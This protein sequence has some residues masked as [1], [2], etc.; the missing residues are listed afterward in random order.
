MAKVIDIVIKVRN[1]A[2]PKLRDVDRSLKRTGMQVK[3]T[4][5]DFTKFNRTLFTTAAFIGTFVKAFQTAVST[6]DA[7]SQLDRVTAQ[8]ERTLGGRGSLIRSIKDMS[9]NSI[10]IIESM[11]AGIALK[12]LGI[13]KSTE[14]LASIVTK[15][16]TA[17]KL[18]GKDSGEGIKSF[19]EFLKTG[20]VENL[21]FL[22][23]I[24]KTNPALKAQLAI[25]RQSGGVMSGVI[26]DAQKLAI[27]Q[28]LL[29]AATKGHLKGERDLRDIL[30]DAGQA[31]K[32]MKAEIGALLGKALGPLIDK[33]TGAVFR[34]VELLEST[35]KTD[36]GI[37]FLVKT[38]AVGTSA[39]LGFAAAIGTLR[40]TALL[41]QSVGIGLP[42]LLAV[43]VGLS[44]VFLGITKTVDGFTEKLSVLG[45][46]IK[47]VFQLIT[48]LDEETGI[49]KIDK[50]IA[51]LLRKHGLLAF[52]QNVARL[53]SIMSSVF[54]D[55]MDG[56][57]RLGVFID[58]TFGG[59]FRGIIDLL[60]GK[61]PWENWFGDGP[62]DML[63]RF[64]V[65][66]GALFAGFAAFKGIKGI[67]GGVGS[68]GKTAFGAAG[69]GLSPLKPLFVS[70]VSGLGKIAGGVGAG[71]IIGTLLGRFKIGGIGAVLKR[72]KD[73]AK[74]G[75][76][77]RLQTLGRFAGFVKGKFKWL[78]SILAT[79]GKS[80]LTFGSSLLG[81]IT[82]VIKFI[83]LKGFGILGAAITALT[84]SDSGA[85]AGTL[86]AK[87]ESGE[88]LT[89][90]E[91]KKLMGQS[92]GIST[93]SARPL[94]APEFVEDS[95][96]Q[97]DILSAALA[98]I[99]ADK[100]AAFSAAITS[101]RG[102]ESAGG[103]DI[104]RDEWVSIFKMALDTS[105]TQRTMAD[106]DLTIQ[107]DANS[108]SER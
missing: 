63:K 14:Q 2:S 7:G 45:N 44:T 57:R 46:F 52:A 87:L 97:E 23:L 65:T 76:G 60:S 11:R 48:S 51:D 73:I 5:A 93:P 13:V 41:L 26:T 86:A 69:R 35:K 3:K 72:F 20:N 89:E 30:L 62:L 101:A 53:G 71:G 82:K 33:V 84:P 56:A 70:D 15:A 43:V 40:L 58:D 68:I 95:A 59:M 91:M 21:Q 75:I 55:I 42:A 106:K 39:V 102:T 9:D 47:G 29:T 107:Q 10:D 105:E 79:A 49:A 38:L 83:G 74:V 28:R 24:A 88:P 92:K 22:N 6:L 37:Q 36:K 34:F 108:R 67:I 25:L 77:R 1:A 61:D 96:Y 32:L 104:T 16:G 18:A 8:F 85:E 80:I 12:S 31:F 54:E 98:S 100:Q 81:I 94:T 4:S 17:A 64:A 103:R 66:A 90:D 19:A 50:E 27:G 99:Q 78:I